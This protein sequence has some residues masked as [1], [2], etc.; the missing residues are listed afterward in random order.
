MPCGRVSRSVRVRD[1]RQEVG[2]GHMRSGFLTTNIAHATG[3]REDGNLQKYLTSAVERIA[4]SMP[5]SETVPYRDDPTSK[6]KPGSVAQE[7][8]RG[9]KPY[10]EVLD[11][12]KAA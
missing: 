1:Q 3:L 7:A 12:L 9:G 11:A 2:V 5:S 6:R 8:M 10:P 4:T